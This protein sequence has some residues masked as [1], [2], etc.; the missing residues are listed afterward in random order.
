MLK[1]DILTLFPSMFVGPFDT[2]MLKKA[3]DR[4]L[5]E[6]NIHNLRDWAIDK[7]KTV[8]DRPYGGGP[9]MVIMVEPVDAA[10][11]TLRS[12]DSHVIMLSPQ[13]EV[14]NSQKATSLAQKK[15]LIFLAGHYEGF[16]ERIKENLV[17]E[18]ISIG[19]YVLTGGE[20]PAMVVTDAVARH[21]PG[22]L[23]PESLV[24]ESFSDG[25]TLDFPVYTRPATYKGW[26]VPEVL[27]DGD[28]KKIEAWRKEKAL[29][30]TK[31]RD[32]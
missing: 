5:V 22:V 7:H 14:F 10:L 23:E 19:N 4:N 24:N 3:K 29:E 28:H 13:G 26:N 16:D 31:A 17:D 27:L 6:I 18:E 12:K 2:S 32:S 1:I 21:I 30:K 11:K 25:E 15:H 20:I 9:G 8:D